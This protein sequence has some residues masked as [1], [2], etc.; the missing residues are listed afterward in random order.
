MTHDDL[1]L[2]E[3]IKARNNYIKQ[4]PQLTK[5]QHELDLALSLLDDPIDRLSVIIK[6]IGEKADELNEILGKIEK[7]LNNQ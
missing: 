5:Y 4:H 1:L 6:K 2:R 3:A 7:E